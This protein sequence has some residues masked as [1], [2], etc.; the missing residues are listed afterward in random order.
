MWDKARQEKELKKRKE[1]ELRDSKEQELQEKERK[2]NERQ[3]KEEEQRDKQE[4]ES[5]LTHLTCMVMMK[6]LKGDYNVLNCCSHS[7]YDFAFSLG[8]LTKPS[9]FVLIPSEDL[10]IKEQWHKRWGEEKRI[11]KEETRLKQNEHIFY[12]SFGC[13]SCNAPF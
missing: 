1:Q 4:N 12:T 7:P 3:E 10:Y 13:L 11:E 2:E 9:L 6:S 5:L 8:T